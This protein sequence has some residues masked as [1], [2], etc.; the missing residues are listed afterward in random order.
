MATDGKIVQ[1]ASTRDTV[2]DVAVILADAIAGVGALA[3]ALRDLKP[4]LAANATEPHQAII[5]RTDATLANV[6]K[7]MLSQYA[8]L[9]A[10]LKRFAG[11]SDA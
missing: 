6:E 5:E 7:V 9:E 3:E 4:V 1:P 2:A 10:V 11:D 8:E